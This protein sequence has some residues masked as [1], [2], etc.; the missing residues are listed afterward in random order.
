MDSTEEL[1]QLDFS[2]EPDPLAVDKSVEKRF[3]APDSCTQRRDPSTD[4]EKTESDDEIEILE[5]RKGKP[6]TSRRSSR[7]AGQAQ[8]KERK[9]VKKNVQKKKVEQK[10]EAEKP[11][12]TSDHKE[13]R[14]KHKHNKDANK[15]ELLSEMLHKTK[16]NKQ[17]AR[18]CEELR[19]QAKRKRNSEGVDPSATKQQKSEKKKKEEKG[20]E[21][22]TKETFFASSDSEE[23][24]I[25]I[26]VLPIDLIWRKR[27]IRC[28]IVREK[29]MLDHELS[30]VMDV[31]KRQK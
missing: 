9:S 6:M 13:S 12:S 3:Q 30:N 2:Q 17:A 22:V 5:V 7:V 26:K 16:L 8:E 11:A 24:E 14:T 31:I 25:E 4:S 23:D 29:W 10:R 18:E 28:K 1:N 15:D 21:K 19:Q 20:K 27:V